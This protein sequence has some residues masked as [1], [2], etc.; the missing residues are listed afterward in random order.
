MDGNIQGDSQSLFHTKFRSELWGW[1][2]GSMTLSID[3]TELKWKGSLIWKVNW[4]W[5]FCWNFP[6]AY[7]IHQTY[8]G[9]P[10]FTSSHAYVLVKQLTSTLFFIIQPNVKQW[11]QLKE[12][13]GSNTWEIRLV[14]TFCSVSEITPF[15]GLHLG[16]LYFN[17]ALYPK[18]EKY[19]FQ[20]LVDTYAYEL[21]TILSQIGMYG[22]SPDFYMLLKESTHIEIKTIVFSWWP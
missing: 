13:R 7:M 11:M 8:H 22:M 2:N 12:Q 14:T 1:K 3:W 18:G 17:I 21:V 20:N 19:F 9:R 4:K 15:V 5:R 6:V 16:F 10:I